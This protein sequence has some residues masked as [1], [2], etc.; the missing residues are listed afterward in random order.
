MTWVSSLS[1]TYQ[2]VHHQ[3]FDVVFIS[4][5]IEEILTPEDR[6]AIMEALWDKVKPGGFIAVIEP[7]SPMGF[8]FINDTRNWLIE[9]GKT[10]A[11]IFAPCPHQN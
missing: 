7:G 4:N 5:V 3:K 9:K 10:E 11:N 8:R 2:F 6:L 1:D